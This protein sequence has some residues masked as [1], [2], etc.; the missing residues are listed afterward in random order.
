[1]IFQIIQLVISFNIEFLN[2]VNGHWFKYTNHNFNLSMQSDFVLALSQ[3]K[4]NY[5]FM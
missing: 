5:C 1:M 4:R 2:H 3:E